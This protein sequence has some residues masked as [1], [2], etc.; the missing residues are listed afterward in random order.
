MTLGQTSRSSALVGQVMALK[1]KEGATPRKPLAVILNKQDLSS[2]DEVS[3][4]AAFLRL[5]SLC[6]DYSTE[7]SPRGGGGSGGGQVDGGGGGACRVFTMSAVTGFGVE[8]FLE[9]TVGLEA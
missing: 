6:A 5:R 7:F 9:W 4:I 3:K 8:E 2:N 1:G